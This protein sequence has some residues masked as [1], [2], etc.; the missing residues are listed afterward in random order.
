MCLINPE[1]V[2]KEVDPAQ[3]PE[4][5]GNFSAGTDIPSGQVF[6]LRQKI[7]LPPTTMLVLR[8]K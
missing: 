2:A 4:R 6:D 5:I 7:H 8:L 1:K 3:F